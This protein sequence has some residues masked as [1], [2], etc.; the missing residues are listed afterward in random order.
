M[1]KLDVQYRDLDKPQEVNGQMINR[2]VSNITW[3]GNQ[4]APTEKQLFGV[5]IQ[6]PQVN[7]T[8]SNSNVTLYFPVVQ[9]W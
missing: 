2:T 5:V 3:S 9:K 4:L 7:L 1:Q 8:G 6:V